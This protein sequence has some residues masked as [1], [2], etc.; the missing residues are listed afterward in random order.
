VGDYFQTV[1]FKDVPLEQS[2][3]LGNKLV[4]WLVEQEIVIGEETDCILSTKKNGYP[5]AKR[6]QLAT[7]QPIDKH[8][9][10]LNTNGV[11]LITGRTV[12][13]AGQMDFEMVCPHCQHKLKKFDECNKAIECWYQ[14]QTI[15]FVKCPACQQSH[16]LLSWQSNYGFSSLGLTFWNWPELALKFLGRLGQI[17]DKK[18]QVVNGK[19]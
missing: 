5:P 7:K 15:N 3:E 19:I 4:R 6:Y 17:I 1:V 9:L 16:D 10:L 13:H 11:E 8:F 18:T 2:L 12:F 14:G